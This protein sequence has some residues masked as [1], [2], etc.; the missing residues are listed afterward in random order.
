IDD[1]PFYDADR[2]RFFIDA[3]HTGPLAGSRA[4]AAGDFREVIVACQRLQRVLPS[5][6]IH[7]IV[8]F[9]NQ[10]HHRTAGISLTKG[11]AAIHATRTL[12]L[13]LVLR[14]RLIHLLPIENTQRDRLPLRALA[15]I[16]HETFWIT[17]GYFALY[18]SHHNCLLTGKRLIA[19]SVYRALLALSFFEDALVVD[20]HDLHELRQRGIERI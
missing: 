18:P 11:H 2:H 10:I 13:E 1:V 14:A 9:G 4:K 7:E 17:H 3:Q 12:D 16:F 5:S 8:P 19:L 20:R 15:G 6:S